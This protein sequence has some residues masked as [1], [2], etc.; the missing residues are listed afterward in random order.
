MNLSPRGEARRPQ[1]IY[2]KQRNGMSQT[3]LKERKNPNFLWNLFSDVRIYKVKS[4][5]AMKVSKY[6]LLI[7]L[8]SVERL[9]W[10]TFKV[11]YIYI[12]IYY[13]IQ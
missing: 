2:L 10:G 4:P 5:L 12:Y 3:L 13:C 9:S 11:V 6:M 7:M 8:G 1:C